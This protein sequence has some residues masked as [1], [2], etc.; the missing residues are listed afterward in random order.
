MLEEV[1]DT[2]K[3]NLSKANRLFGK[4]RLKEIKR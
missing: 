3:S 2:Y 1:Y 4:Y